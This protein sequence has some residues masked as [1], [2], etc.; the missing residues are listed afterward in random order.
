M[1]IENER[2]LRME[3]GT[4]C[5]LPPPPTHP[6]F[7]AAGAGILRA[8]CVRIEEWEGEEA[9]AER[10]DVPSYYLPRGAQQWGLSLG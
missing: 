9:A 7:P 1:Q 5:L 4:P 3:M 8:L 6:Y 2:M 10:I